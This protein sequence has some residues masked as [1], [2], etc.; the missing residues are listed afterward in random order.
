M[1]NDKVKM[2]KTRE[3]LRDQTTLLCEFKALF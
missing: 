2:L 1:L 3:Y